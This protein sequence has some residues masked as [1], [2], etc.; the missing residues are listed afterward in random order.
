MMTKSFFEVLEDQNNLIFLIS[1]LNISE[2]LLGQN[3]D[4]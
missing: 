3:T 2:A 1:P 4:K